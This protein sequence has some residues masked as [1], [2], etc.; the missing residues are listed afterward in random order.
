MFG[1]PWLLGAEAGTATFGPNRAAF[2]EHGLRALAATGLPSADK[3]AMLLTVTGYT[4]GAAQVFLSTARVVAERGVREEEFGAALSRT[5][6]QVVTTER[7]PA[8]AEAIAGGA[9][10]RGGGGRR[11]DRLQVR[12]R[13]HPRRHRRVRHVLTHRAGSFGTV[14][15]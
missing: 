9:F 3:L 8:I 12:S 2:M 11:A 14:G 5:L 13:P 4:H 6:G 15:A 10:R 7:F 1:H